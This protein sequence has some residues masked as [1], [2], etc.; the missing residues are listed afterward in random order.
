MS[1]Y[2]HLSPCHR[3]TMN[4]SFELTHNTS[5]ELRL[6]DHIGSGWWFGD[7]GQAHCCV[8]T[9][10]ACDWSFASNRVLS[11][12]FYGIFAMGRI[13]IQQFYITTWVKYPKDLLRK[14][15]Q[16]T[17]SKMQYQCNFRKSK[18]MVYKD[19]KIKCFVSFIG[20]G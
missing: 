12:L 13:R 7:K 1:D 2:A 15:K 14:Y 18:N 10:Q 5:N 17:K 20:K 8:V 9:F 4:L 3:V 11:L 19:E 16:G 6:T